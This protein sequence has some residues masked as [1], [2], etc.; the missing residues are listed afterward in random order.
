MAERI[1]RDADYTT[2]K[3]FAD[4]ALGVAVPSELHYHPWIAQLK[5]A[6]K[7][8]DQMK[9]DV[10]LLVK[11]FPSLQSI[12]H[13][14]VKGW[15]DELTAQQVSPNSQQRMVSFCRNYWGYLQTLNAVPSDSQP[16][17]KQ[18]GNKK[19]KTTKKKRGADGDGGPRL[20]FTATEV[21]KLWKA[22]HTSEDEQLADLIMLGAYS[23]TRIEELCSLKVE[24]VSNA[25]FKITDAKTRAG[26]REVPIHSKI[27]DLVQR[28]KRS[29]KDGYLV[30]GLTFNKYGDRSNAIGKRF[31]R[32]KTAE[33]FGEQHVFHSFR[34]TLITL[35]E[36]AGVPEGVAADI[37]GHE[38]K[39][40]TYGLYSGGA[41]LD[42]KAKAIERVK[43]PFGSAA[44]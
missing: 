2:A 37:A 28:L 5:L 29:S 17:T 42:V 12:S 39:T 31:G 25:S 40:M 41:T 22:A 3:R 24:D 6:P 20:P 26:I 30:S 13:Q 4:I 16:F 23:G 11:R 10:S 9:K 43:Y 36:N 35:L 8:M 15:L 14:S 19:R 18:A 32:L 34:K 21:V 1:E 7:T 27:R 33:G 38:K 44:A